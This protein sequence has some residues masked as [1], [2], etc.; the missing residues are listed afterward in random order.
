LLS[1]CISMELSLWASAEGVNSSSKG[2]SMVSVAGGDTRACR[3]PAPPVEVAPPW[4]RVRTGCPAAPAHAEHGGEAVSLP[5]PL[6]AHW[7][8]VGA[9]QGVCMGRWKA[10]P[11]P[12]RPFA[13]RQRR[14]LLACG[15]TRDY[16]AHGQEGGDGGLHDVGGDT[17]GRMG[18]V[19]GFQR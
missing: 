15:R 8:R 12:Q 18:W 7:T 1:A 3:L 14:K 13:G 19:W 4:S 2:A 11:L 5:C 9:L 16:Q 10:F 6:E 17:R